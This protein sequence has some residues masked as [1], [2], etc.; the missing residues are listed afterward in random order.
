MEK[1]RII[2]DDGIVECPA[3]SFV[4]TNLRAKRVPW[5]YMPYTVPEHG[6][7]YHHTLNGVYEIRDAW[8]YTHSLLQGWGNEKTTD[9]QILMAIKSLG[10]VPE[11]DTHRLTRA[12]ANCVHK[13]ETAQITPPHRDFDKPGCVYIYYVNDSD[14]DTILFDQDGNVEVKVTPEAGHLLR[15]DSGQWHCQTTPV[16]TDRRMVINLNFEQI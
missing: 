13:T 7:F 8:F 3:V 16:R 9:H 2:R 6:K 1:Y 4:A 12:Q 15:I 5:F 10:V 11:F 14:G